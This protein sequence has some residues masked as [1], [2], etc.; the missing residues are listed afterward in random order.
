[1][2]DPDNSVRDSNADIVVEPLG[3]SVESEPADGEEVEEGG[4]PEHDKKGLKHY[5]IRDKILLCSSI[6]PLFISVL[7]MLYYLPVLG[8]WIFG[9]TA[10]SKSLRL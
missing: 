3:E 4:R 5:T 2:A 1:M 6:L 9:H 8:E 7:Y 10:L